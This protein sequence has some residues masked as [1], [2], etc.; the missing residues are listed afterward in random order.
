MQ[1]LHKAPADLKLSCNMHLLK[2]ASSSGFG[3][4]L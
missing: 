1:F 3:K 2:I 4:L